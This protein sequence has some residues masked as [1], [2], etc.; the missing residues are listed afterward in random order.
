MS[1]DDPWWMGGEEQAEEYEE[2]FDV[3]TRRWVR[4]SKKLTIYEESYEYPSSNQALMNVD[5]SDFRPRYPDNPVDSC[6]EERETGNY[7]DSEKSGEDLD[8]EVDSGGWVSL[9]SGSDLL[10][11]RG[12]AWKPRKPFQNTAGLKMYI[13]T[14]SVMAAML[15]MSGRF[16]ELGI[17]GV[18]ILIVIQV[19]RWRR[20]A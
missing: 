4:V 10:R 5:S 8:G 16:L 7:I 20:W 14:S 15:A 17:V 12:A 2:Y 1:R 11:G 13:A 6:S 19:S 3:E 18:S 9:D